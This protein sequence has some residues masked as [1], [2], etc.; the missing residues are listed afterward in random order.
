MLRSKI[1]LEPVEVDG[2]R[3]YRFKAEGTYERLLSGEALEK[4]PRTVVAPTGGAP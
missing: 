3:G 1:D 4:L 2:Q